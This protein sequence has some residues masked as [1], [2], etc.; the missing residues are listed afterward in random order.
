MLFLFSFSSSS[1]L[2]LV[3]P[4]YYRDGTISEKMDVYALGVVLLELLTARPAHAGGMSLVTLAEEQLAELVEKDNPSAFMALLDA[5]IANEPDWPDA[6]RTPVLETA[7]LAARCLQSRAKK[8]PAM[9][10]EA[11]GND[12][13]AVLPAALAIKAQLPQA[14]RANRPDDCVICLARLASMAVVPC[15]HVCLCAQCGP[16]VSGACPLCNG[17]IERV[18]ALRF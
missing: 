7:R 2:L 3:S 17:R 6:L 10:G 14:M 9:V 13:L 5:H 15:G 18:M 8:R 1:Y 16:T 12:G 4:E 11:A